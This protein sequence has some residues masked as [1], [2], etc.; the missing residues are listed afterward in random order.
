MGISD[1]PT[2]CGT[3]RQEDIRFFREYV[4]YSEITSEPTPDKGMGFVVESLKFG[5]VILSNISLSIREPHF[6]NVHA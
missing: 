6:E 2:Y 1:L 4:R 3:I 5:K